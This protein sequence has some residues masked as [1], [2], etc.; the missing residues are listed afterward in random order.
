MKVSNNVSAASNRM[1]LKLSHLKNHVAM[2]YYTGPR[3][4]SFEHGNET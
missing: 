3:V 4:G 2:K 1:K